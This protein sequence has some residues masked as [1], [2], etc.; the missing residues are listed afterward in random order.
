MSQVKS[1]YELH[2]GPCMAM[3][4]QPKYSAESTL[5]CQLKEQ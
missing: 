1:I 3:M 2:S 4:L 5:Q